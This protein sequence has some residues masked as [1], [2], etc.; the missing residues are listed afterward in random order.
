MIAIINSWSRRTS[1]WGWIA[2]TPQPATD[3]HVEPIRSV[4][5]Y[6]TVCKSSCGLNFVIEGG[7]WTVCAPSVVF[8]IHAT[9]TQTRTKKGETCFK[10]IVSSFEQLEGWIHWNR[11]F[12]FSPPKYSFKRKKGKKEMKPSW[13]PEEAYLQLLILHPAYWTFHVWA[14]ASCLDAAHPSSVIYGSPVSHWMK[15][16]KLQFALCLFFLLQKF[17]NFLLR[18]WNQSGRK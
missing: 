13:T 4:L 2:P 5:E 8:G 10:V 15:K 17:W 6:A 12:F 16:K 11:C 9:K 1:F 7:A 18:W 3:R 14:S